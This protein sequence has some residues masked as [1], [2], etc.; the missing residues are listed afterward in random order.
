VLDAA[1]APIH[2]LRAKSVELLVLLAVR[3]DGAA[4]T[5]ILRTVWP[6][7]APQKAAQRLST[8]LGNLRGTIR[9]AL[10]AIDPAYRSQAVLG[11]R[12]EP[13]VNT[14]GHYRLEPAILAVDWWQLQDDHHARVPSAAEDVLSAAH[15]RIAVGCD[16]PWL[17]RNPQ[18]GDA[19][20]RYLVRS[21][22]RRMRRPMAGLRAALLLPGPGCRPAVQQVVPHGVA[23][24]TWCKPPA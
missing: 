3:R 2:G 1:G 7:V 23:D 6:D 17:A 21:M 22:D 5:E 11:G 24:A 20:A 19:A 18:L 4:L 10:G 12:L 16:Y 9:G 13:V 15:A 14:G 8:C